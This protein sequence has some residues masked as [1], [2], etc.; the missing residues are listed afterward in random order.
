MLATWVFA[1]V[2]LGF[3]TCVPKEGNYLLVPDTPVMVCTNCG[4]VYYD[5]AILEAIEQRFFA[6]QQEGEE[7]DTYIQMPLVAYA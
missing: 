6:I 5:A 3:G 1:I 7:P 4:M 2:G